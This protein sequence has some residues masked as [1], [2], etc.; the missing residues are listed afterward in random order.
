MIRNYLKIALRH[1]QKNR[2]YTVINLA[3]LAIGI[4]GCLL[5]GLY[6]W[7]E[8]SYD[9]FHANAN[10]IVRVSWEFKFENETNQTALTGSRVGPEFTRRFLETEAY[11]RLMKYPRV[12]AVEDKMFEEK[13][14]LYADSAFFKVFSFPLLQGDPA[15]ALDA[16]E[17]LVITESMARKYFGSQNPIGKTLNVGGTKDFQV[18]GIAADAPDNSQ[19]KFDFV[20]SFKSLNA[21][22]EEK[23]TEANYLTYLLLGSPEEITP[24]QAKVAEYME[25]VGKEE[26][27]L[28]NG[29]FMTY[30]LEPLTNVHLHSSLD[31]FEPNSSFT[32]IY[33]LAAVALLILLIGCVNYTNLSTA[34]SAGRSSEIGM[35]KVMGAAKK[36]IFFQFISEALLLALLAVVVALLLSAMLLPHFNLLSGKDLQREI[37]YEP[38]TLLSLLVLSGVVA[39][40]AGAYPAFILSNGKV[41]RILK[42]GFAFSGSAGLRKSLIVFQFVISIFLIIS[43][44]VILQQLSFIQNKDLGYNK[45]QVVILPIDSRIREN[46]DALRAAVENVP[47]VASV[48]AAYEEPTHIGWSDALTSR[49]DNQR[50]SVNAMPVDESMIKTLGVQIIA[51]SPYTLS[52]IH[53]A[54]P[55]IYGDTIRY[56]YMLNEA[57]VRTLGWTPEEAIGKVVAKGREGVVRAVVKD[58][59]FRSLHESIGP[60]VIFMDKRLVGSM[61]VKI[62][63]SNMRETLGR[64][65]TVWKQRVAHR[66][67]EYQFLDENYTALYRAEQSIAGVFSA[68]STVAILLACLGLFALTA[69]AMVRRSKEIGIRKVLGASVPDILSL[70]SKDFV[71]LVGIAVVIAIP[72]ALLAITKWLDGFTYRVDVEWWV[73][74]AASLV[75]L[76]FATITV[77]LQAIKTAR[78]NPVKNL[79]SE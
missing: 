50:I 60:L 25:E 72:L 65:G 41:I 79:R 56:T 31:G 2:L 51:G 57:A 59:H 78:I 40:L 43:T 44:V 76:L 35:R 34:Q 29:N 22:K 55:A 70:V 19:I 11:V 75:T 3:G 67:F 46:Y 23:W 58:F 73:F 26:L 15:T 37:L 68:F 13:N 42:S 24:L 7:H 63:D 17:K 49:E 16:P 8:L 14:F 64:L 28:Q 4:C 39:L 38:A 6:I 45:E 53:R 71:K 33:V 48:G 30:H 10:R 21:F 27:K 61:F 62:T 1:L 18:T 47:G 32:Y 69:F 9:R 12:L 36:D 77:C 54:D 66:P 5:I 52:D 74:V 20:G